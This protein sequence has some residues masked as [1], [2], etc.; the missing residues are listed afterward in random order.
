MRRGVRAGLIVTV[1]AAGLLLA[2]AAGA[3]VKKAGGISYVSVKFELPASNSKQGIFRRY[4]AKCPTG[5]HVLGG[6]ERNNSAFDQVRMAQSYPIDDRSDATKKPDDGWGVLLQ[7]IAEVKQRGKVYAQCAKTSVKYVEE[8]NPVPGATQGGEFETTCPAGRYIAGG[9]TKG[10]KLL[11]QNALYPYDVSTG[12]YIDN[13]D[14]V[15]RTITGTAICIRRNTTVQTF[16]S[17]HMNGPERRRFDLNCPAGTHVI[18]GGQSNSAS[19]N[20]Y[21]QSQFPTADGGGAP[22]DGWAVVM[23]LLSAGDRTVNPA[24]VC[25]PAL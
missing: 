19:F 25:A 6:G 12:Y 16:G 7:N 20:F 3:S 10:H 11:F 5:T 17:T 8:K 14:A 9:G 22:D 13:F 18:S 4:V 15:E 23:E 2:P 21:A 1:L 24:V